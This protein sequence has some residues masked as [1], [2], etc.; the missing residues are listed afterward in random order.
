MGMHTFW[1]ETK[2][3]SVDPGTTPTAITINGRNI[4]TTERFTYLGSDVDSSGNSSPD[5]RRRI[6]LAAS[7]MGRL[8]R[9]NFS[10]FL[11]SRHL[12]V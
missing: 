4:N 6:G 11:T 7:T 10:N 3:Q 12:I 1:V 5:I 9:L 2:I 8:K